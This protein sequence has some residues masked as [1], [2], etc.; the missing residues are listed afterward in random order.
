M[1]IATHHLLPLQWMGRA[2]VYVGFLLGMT[3]ATDGDFIGFILDGILG[4]MYLM[5]ATAANIGV[6]VVVTFPSNALVVIVAT[7]TN[8]ILFLSRYWRILAK[9]DHWLFATFIMGTQWAV[10]GFAL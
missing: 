4:R 6:I 9:G 10:T 8:A 7:H 1:A 2:F 5:A 3:L